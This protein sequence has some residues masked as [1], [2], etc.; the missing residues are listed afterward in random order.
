MK[1]AKMSTHSPKTETRITLRMPAP[2]LHVIER[3][4]RL[5]SLTTQA[6]ILSSCVAAAEKVVL[7]QVVF[8]FSDKQAE[9]LEAL[10]SERMLGSEAMLKLLAKKSPWDA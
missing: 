8:E 3:A 5:K 6:F 4:A 2:A 10:L 7:D 1:K 9:S